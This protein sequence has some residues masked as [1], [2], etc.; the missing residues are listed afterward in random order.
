VANAFR[1]APLHPA[2][3]AI[4]IGAGMI[5]LLLIEWLKLKRS[6]T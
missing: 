1:F 5:S 2:D 6:E 3:L 4:C